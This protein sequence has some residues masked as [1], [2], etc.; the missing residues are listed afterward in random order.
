MGKKV[1]NKG[2][3]M[4]RL[5]KIIPYVLFAC[6]GLMACADQSTPTPSPSAAVEASVVSMEDLAHKI[7]GT[8][9]RVMAEEHIPGAAIVI[10][11]NGKTVFKRGYGFAN[12]DENTKV[13][14]DTTLFRIGSVTKALTL[15]A[16]VRLADEGV[17]D[18][19]DP[20]EKYVPAFADIPNVSGSNSP[21]KIRHLVTHTTG[22]DQIGLD[23]HIW[24]LEKTL[25]ER[26]AVR[27]GLE[28]FLFNGNL[29]RTSPPGLHYRYDTYGTTLAGLIL[30]KVTGKDYA[31]AMDEVLFSP[32]GMSR[33]YVEAS[34]IVF[35]DLALGYGYVGEGYGVAPYEVYVTRPA[36][37]IDATPADMGRFLEALTQ[38]QTLM[39]PQFRPH[40]DFPGVTKGLMEFPVADDEGRHPIRAI[41]H[42][43]SMLGFKTT[44]T[45]IPDLKLGYFIAS[46]RNAEAGGSR[47]SLHG[48]INDLVLD[49]YHS[50]EPPQMESIPEVDPKTDLAAYEGSYY[51]GVFCKSCTEAEFARGAWNK[52]GPKIVSS[53]D[54][55]L[56]LDDDPYY[57]SNNQEGVFIGQ[58][59]S[60][61]VHFGKSPNGNISFFSYGSSPDTFE[62]IVDNAQR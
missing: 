48:K 46:N 16:L 21:V 59:G 42:G 45:L 27:P 26:K 17:V 56:F 6:G 44:I 4:K 35:D 47:V 60:Q 1:P 37:S 34:T 8:A 9:A 32:L 55:V 40:P 29:R 62:R 52:R 13:S 51:Y 43:G 14:A 11:E 58:D 57:M 36:S 20:V 54:G 41:G 53:K 7:D 30:E 15:Q 28:A 31:K 24:E 50:A 38:D 5:H 10:V 3:R 18:M 2:Q 12:I 39:T 49:A 23:R 19:D 25:E 22:L 61:K 33:S